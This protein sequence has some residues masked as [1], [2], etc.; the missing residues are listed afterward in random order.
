MLKCNKG[1]NPHPYLGG[2]GGKYG[3][4]WILGENTMLVFFSCFSLNVKNSINILNS[5]MI[6]STALI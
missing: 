4:Y 6:F 3:K 5:Y 2:F 1:E